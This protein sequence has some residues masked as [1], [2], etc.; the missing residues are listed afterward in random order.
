MVDLQIIIHLLNEAVKSSDSYLEQYYYEDNQSVL[1]TKKVLL[2]LKNEIENNPAK[3]DETIL[4]AMHDVGISSYKEFENTPLE[5]TINEVTEW[6]Y[7]NI[8]S[9]KNLSPL[10]S[11]FER[12]VT[13]SS[14]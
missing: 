11:D 3:V 6:L 10:G 1:D 5:K 14:S 4:R 2:R 8:P 12:W 7:E 13:E 9:Y